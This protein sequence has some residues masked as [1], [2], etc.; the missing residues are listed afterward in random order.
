M[1]RHETT[2]RVVSKVSLTLNT[3]NKLFVKSNRFN[4]IEKIAAESP[5]SSFSPFNSPQPQE[6][7]D[8]S[9]NIDLVQTTACSQPSKQSTDIVIHIFRPKLAIYPQSR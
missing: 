2:T 9:A 6:T 4:L 8:T 7:S 1:R 3:N 5:T